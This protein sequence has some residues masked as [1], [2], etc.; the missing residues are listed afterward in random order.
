MEPVD[1]RQP[2]VA[3][4]M[5]RFP[6][7]TETFILYEILAL[8]RHG[9]D[10]Q[11]YPL[12][13]ERKTRR[14][15]DG[16]SPLGKAINLVSGESG[17]LV[18]HDEARTLLPRVH[19]SPLISRRIIRAMLGALVRDPASFLTTLGKVVAYNVGSINY[20]LGGLA[21]FPKAIYLGAEMRRAGVTHVH[22]HFA[23][24]PTTAVYVI[25]RMFGIPYSFTGHGADLQVD[26]HM[27]REKVRAAVFV[28]A[29]AD[30]GRSLILAHA[31]HDSAA[32][33]VTVPCG[34]DSAV[35]DSPPRIRSASTQLRLLCVAT[36]YEVKGHHYLFKA[37]ALLVDRGFDITCELVGDGPDRAALEMEVATMG[38]ADRITFL[39]PQ[40]RSEI[41]AH[42]HGADA[43]VVPSVPT[44]SGRREGL[45]VVIME[46]MA[47]R[48]A[49]VA[50]GISGI[51]EIVIDGETGL[52]VPPRDPDAIANAVGLLA[53]DDAMRQRLV[54]AAHDLVGRRYDLAV[55][56][57]RMIELFSSPGT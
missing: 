10:V 57:K 37:I 4:V 18:M 47:A 5:S 29:I 45:P 52:L 49:V 32:K 19:Y 54:E 26:Q 38:L 13:R 14:A 35:F 3:Y 27:L 6:R 8:R 20:L 56:S 36:M 23:N 46:A 11:V 28:R 42:M 43:L 53:G 41:V 40:T 7:L 2:R 55:V 33:V 1:P 15:P 9:L 51:P 48:L 30:D 31:P 50:S 44:T 22:A 17:E 12:M 16:A 25:W 24:H 34:V 21:I 39:G